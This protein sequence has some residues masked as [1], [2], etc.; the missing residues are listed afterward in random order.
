MC[1]EYEK[2]DTSGGKN[3]NFGHMRV[4][5][6]LALE[7]ADVDETNDLSNISLPPEKPCVD[8]FVPTKL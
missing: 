3:D 4:T 8:H 5:K 6:I 1:A 2:A 7:H